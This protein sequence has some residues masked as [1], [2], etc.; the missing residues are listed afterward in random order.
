MTITTTPLPTPTSTVKL[1][2]LNGGSMAAEYHKL[3]AG[4]PPAK[5]F[6]MYNRCFLI[7]H[8]AQ[9]RWVVAISRPLHLPGTDASSTRIS[10][11]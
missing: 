9:K 4:G 10:Q 8:V 3:R 11:M 7:H 5:E 1:Y 2:L 6:R